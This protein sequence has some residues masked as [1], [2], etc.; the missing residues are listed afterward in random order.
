[1]GACNRLEKHIAK[2]WRV[3]I[4]IVHHNLVNY[5]YICKECP[6]L[7]SICGAY[8]LP[9]VSHHRVTF[10]SIEQMRELADSPSEVTKS[11]MREGVVIVSAERPDAMAKVIGFEYL[12]GKDRTERK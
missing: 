8:Q 12:T 9:V 2:L 11:H 4:E 5:R 7:R 10:K 3:S 1:M 6:E